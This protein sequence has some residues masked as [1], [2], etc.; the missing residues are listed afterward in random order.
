MVTVIPLT[1]GPIARYLLIFGDH[2][3]IDFL[4]MEVLFGEG[5][6]QPHAIS[7]L[8]LFLYVLMAIYGRS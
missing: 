7:T 2:R 3:L 8:N 4:R 6:L 5:M 1:F